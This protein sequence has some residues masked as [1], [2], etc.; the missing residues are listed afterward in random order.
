MSR[1]SAVSIFTP[2]LIAIDVPF[3]GFGE[4]SFALSRG[5]H[6]RLVMTFETTHADVLFPLLVIERIE[7]ATQH[8]GGVRVGVVVFHLIGRKDGIVIFT[9]GSV[10]LFFLEWFR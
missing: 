2:A 7:A 6:P 4:C 8:A 10:L 9:H 5:C 1:R 3:D